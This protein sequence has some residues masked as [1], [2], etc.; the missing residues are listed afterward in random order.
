[1]TTPWPKAKKKIEFPSEIHF[2]LGL[3][4]RGGQTMSKSK[5][6]GILEWKLP[7]KVSPRMGPLQVGTAK[8]LHSCSAAMYNS[9]MI[10]K[11]PYPQY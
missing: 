6:S 5:K 7:P 2:F 9:H 8:E 4:P 11:I 10:G 3:R 1:M